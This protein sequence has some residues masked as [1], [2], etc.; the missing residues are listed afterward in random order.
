MK[1]FPSGLVP[2]ALAV[3]A[4]VA[5]QLCAA[6][7]FLSV[8]QAQKDMFGAAALTATPVVL[9]AAQQDRLK[10]VSSVA[11]PFQGNRVWRAA[12]GGWFVVDEVVGKHELITYAVGLNADGTVRRV[13]VLEY[14]ESYGGE[15]AGASWL[16]QFA[17]KSAAAP[18]KV[19]QDIAN[20]SGATLSSKHLADGVRRVLELHASVLRTM[21]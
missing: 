7:V 12:D 2:I 8:E 18:V 9:T 16:K 17:G 19:G 11:L 13:E 6:K 3:P 21:G 1:W 4:A 20:I 10:E 14:R 5:P 15:V